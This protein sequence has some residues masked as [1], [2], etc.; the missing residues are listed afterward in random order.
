MSLFR[1]IWP[2]LLQ[3]WCSPKFPEDLINSSDAH[4]PSTPTGPTPRDGSWPSAFMT[5]AQEVLTGRG[6]EQL[7]P[8]VETSDPTGGQKGW[9]FSACGCFS[10][11]RSFIPSSAFPSSPTA[12][13]YRWPLLLY[14]RDSLL[15]KVPW[16]MPVASPL[17]PLQL[18]SVSRRDLKWGGQKDSLWEGSVLSSPTTSTCRTQCNVGLCCF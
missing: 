1:Q 4:H 17:W 10:F 16:N 12:P 13:S 14:K 8:W 18:L 7:P 3:L 11:S 6:W 2:V 5:I 15:L 9:L